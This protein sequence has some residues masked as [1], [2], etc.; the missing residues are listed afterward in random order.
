MHGQEVKTE[1][2]HQRAKEQQ[3]K[4]WMDGG[5]GQS[6]VIAA[7]GSVPGNQLYSVPSASRVVEQRAVTNG[8]ITLLELSWVLADHLTLGTLVAVMGGCQWMNG[9]M[10]SEH[11][12]EVLSHGDASGV[13]TR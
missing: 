4:T 2:I 8:W 13:L 11:T 9:T 5:T 6:P 1:R 10:K 12:S 7:T 3:G